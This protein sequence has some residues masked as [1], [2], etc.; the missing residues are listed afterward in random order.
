[1]K[2]RV[3]SRT[4]QRRTS[5][6]LRSVALT[7]CLVVVFVLGTRFSRPPATVSD[8]TPQANAT[9]TKELLLPVPLHQVAAGSSL[10]DVEFV[11]VPWPSGKNVDAYI[12]DVGP[13]KKYHTRERLQAYV[14]VASAALVATATDTNAVVERIPEGMRAITVKVDA[15]SAVEG[16]A[17]SGSHIDVLVIRQLPDGD[18]RFET[19]VIAENVRILSAGRSVKTSPDAPQT[20]ATVTLLVDQADALRI[21]TAA[22]LGKL[23]FSLRGVGD[24][25]PT[26]LR[27][28]NQRALLGTPRNS[29]PQVNPFRG[30]AVAADGTHWVLTEGNRWIRKAGSDPEVGKETLAENQ[31]EST[32][33]SAQLAEASDVEI[34]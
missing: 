11:Y 32:S 30:S 7:A 24:T 31:H 9:E 14:P 10:A 20:P 12:R 21:K 17:Q 1:M 25:E 22:N 5:A 34:Q 19:K 16:W 28:M 8:L 27:H 23:T 26:T 3:K 29:L 4:Y 18:N 6:L 15:E 33:L 13:F 2:A